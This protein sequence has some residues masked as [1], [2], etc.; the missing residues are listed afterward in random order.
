MNSATAQPLAPKSAS[1]RRASCGILPVARFLARK[2]KLIRICIMISQP[3]LVPPEPALNT[4]RSELKSN[5]ERAWRSMPSE[6]K[7]RGVEKRARGKGK[8]S[9]RNKGLECAQW[10][11]SFRA[12]RSIRSARA[13]NRRLAGREWQIYGGR[14]RHLG[15]NT[16]LKPLSANSRS[17]PRARLRPP[18]QER[19]ERGRPAGNKRGNYLLANVHSH[20][21]P[22]RRGGGRGRIYRIELC[23]R[24]S[25]SPSSLWT[26]SRWFFAN[27]L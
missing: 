27:A 23:F 4:P 10:H 8:E 9:A 12:I 6:A 2:I 17:L 13:R 18:A 16:L 1:S 15:W 25:G 22:G 14:A 7:E 11:E 24:L 26:I 19:R 5:R 20:F 3:R 21:F